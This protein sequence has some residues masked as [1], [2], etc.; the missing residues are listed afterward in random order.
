MSCSLYY[1]GGDQNLAE[2]LTVEIQNKV[3]KIVKGYYWTGKL[4]GKGLLGQFRKTAAKKR[5]LKVWM[6][7]QSIDKYT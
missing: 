2:K 3:D 5:T 1:V 4:E 6:K 7:K